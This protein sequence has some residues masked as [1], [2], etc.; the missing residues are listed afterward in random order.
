MNELS[1]DVY[2]N[3]GSAVH[4]RPQSG[5]VIENKGSYALKAGILLK[6]QGGRLE[7]TDCRWYVVGGRW[8]RAG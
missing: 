2:E 4:G 8:G 1:G 7:V 5:N 6:R 3:K